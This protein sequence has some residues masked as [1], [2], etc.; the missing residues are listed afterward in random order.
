MKKINVLISGAT[1]H[2]GGVLMNKCPDELVIKA[3]SHSEVPTSTVPVFLAKYQTLIKSLKGQDVVL[4][5]AARNN[6][7][8]GSEDEFLA[9]NCTLTVNL[10]GAAVS[11]GVKRFIYVT[12]TH[13]LWPERTGFYVKSKK[14]AEQELQKISDPRC[15]LVLLRLPAVWGPGSKGRL[16]IL[17][18]CPTIFRP[19]LHQSLRSLIPI[20]GIERVISTIVHLITAEKVQVETLPSDPLSKFSPYSIFSFFL[21]ASFV[22]TVASALLPALLLVA[23]CVRFS[24]PGPAF[25]VQERV[26]HKGEV[27]RCVKFRTMLNGTVSRASHE[28]SMCQVTRLGRILRKTK[29]DELPQAWNVLTGEMLLIGP[30]P[31]LQSQL[32]LTEVRAVLNVFDNKPGITGLGQIQ[33]IDMS[34]PEQL[35]L[36]DYRYIQTRS[37]FG[38]I[39]IILATVLG[40][41]VGDA[42]NK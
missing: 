41:G 11:A 1:G 5:L 7:Q 6:D 29:F 10:Y 20:V 34:T 9:D 36:E 13:A 19:L 24:S 38:D 12:T 21:N 22:L 33:K 40:A 32:H 26:G 42:A 39:K 18:K 35:A 27:F 3:L 31:G 8:S 30:R 23:I 14:N 16:R 15:E 28:V 17:I 37:I 25:F 2:I 4:H